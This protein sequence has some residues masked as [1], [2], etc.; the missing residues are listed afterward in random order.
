M[1]RMIHLRFPQLGRM[2]SMVRDAGKATY[3]MVIVCVKIYTFSILLAWVFLAS[4]TTSAKTNARL[5]VFVRYV[6][7][8]MYLHK[9]FSKRPKERSPWCS[10]N[11]V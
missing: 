8:F 1:A 4:G 11:L 2:L 3:G 5:T 6:P 10:A 7:Y 9:A